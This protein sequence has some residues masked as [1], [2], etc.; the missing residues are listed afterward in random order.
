[1][2]DFVR[3]LNEEIPQLTH[4]VLQILQAKYQKAGDPN[5]FEF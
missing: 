1:M 5:S 4:M 3:I 2:N